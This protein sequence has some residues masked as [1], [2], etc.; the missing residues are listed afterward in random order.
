MSVKFYKIQRNFE[1][2]LIFGTGFRTL[3][4]LSLLRPFSLNLLDE[5]N[6]QTPH[7]THLSRKWTH[8]RFAGPYIRNSDWG[9]RISGTAGAIDSKIAPTRLV[10]RDLKNRTILIE[11]RRIRNFR[12]PDSNPIETGGSC[13]MSVY[14]TRLYSTRRIDRH[15]TR[16]LCLENGRTSGLWVHIYGFRLWEDVS[17]QPLGRSTRKLHPRDRSV[18]IFRT[19]PPS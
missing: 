14:S 11:L 4:E 8:F 18:E 3:S 2:F 19:V 1:R 7:T 10:R 13:E 15:L 17:R 12:D 5:T 6:R 16:P 9:P